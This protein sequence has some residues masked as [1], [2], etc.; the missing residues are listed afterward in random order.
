MLRKNRPT[1]GSTERLPQVD[2]SFTMTTVFAVLRAPDA[3]ARIPL[4]SAVMG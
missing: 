1:T 3:Y 4:N 2:L